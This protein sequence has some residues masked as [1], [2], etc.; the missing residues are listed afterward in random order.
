MRE[1]DPKELLDRTSLGI[2]PLSES[3]LPDDASIFE[4]LVAAP[5]DEELHTIWTVWSIVFAL[6]SFIILVVFFAIISSKRVRRQ[7]FNHYLIYLMLPDILYTVLCTIQCGALAI[8]G[9]NNT[10]ASCRLQ[11]FYLLFGNGANSWMNALIANQIHT[12]L[13]VSNRCGRYVPPTRR[14]IALQSR[15]AYAWA[16]FIAILGI[17]PESVGIP[18][19]TVPFYGLGCVAVSYDRASN[20]FFWLF[21]Y[22][23]FA[24]I[25]MLYLIYVTVDI[26]RKKLLPREGRRREI[27]LYYVRILVAVYVMWCESS[28]AFSD[29]GFVY[30]YH[31]MSSLTLHCS[32]PSFVILDFRPCSLSSRIGDNLW[33][34]SRR[35]AVYVCRALDPRPRSSQ[36]P[37]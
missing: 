13:K 26:W 3:E 10:P 30:Y 25:P 35:L 36:C 20:L 17:L 5:D 22:P 31:G 9:G 21:F 33:V 14:K 11:S 1:L 18:I 34:F 24:A 6:Y 32:S 27:S 19:M 15:C 4:V 16:A 37:M 23:A 29:A 12:L 8:T 2:S 28:E 7:P